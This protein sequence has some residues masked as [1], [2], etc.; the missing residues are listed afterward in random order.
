LPR[1]AQYE[2]RWEAA[3]AAYRTS[4]ESQ[5]ITE[6]TWGTWL[7]QH[8][9]FA[10]QG[11]HGRIN[12]L[13]ERRHGGENGYWY[14]Y[15]RQGKHVIKQYAGRSEQLTLT[16]LEALT[17]LMCADRPIATPAHTAEPTLPSASSLIAPLPLLAAKLQPPRLRTGLVPRER[18]LARLD[19][20]H[21]G[22][23][24]LIAAPAGFGKTTLVNQWVTSR[25]EAGIFS[26]VA[27]LAL[28]AGDADPARFWRYFI[29]TCQRLHPDVGHDAM[30]LLHA[31]TLPPFE[32]PSPETVLTLLLNDLI[33][34]QC[35][36]VLV[37]EDYHFITAPQIH[38]ALVFFIEHLSVGLHLI[39]MTRRDP[40]FPLARW[41]AQGIITEITPA[42]L[43]FTPDETAAFFQA[44]STFT[45]DEKVLAQIESRLEGW[46]AGLRM[47]ALALQGHAQPDQ[48]H[49]WLGEPNGSQWIFGDYF[50]AEV[51]ETQPEEIQQFLLMTSSL[52]RISGELC[53][54]VLERTGSTALLDTMER[55][56]L[57]L[58]PLEQHGNWYRFH[59][60][61]AEA[62]QR[63]AQR[64]LDDARLAGA[65]QRASA[66]Y[67]AHDMLPEAIE[68]ALHIRDFPHAAH[69]I[70]RYVGS[71]L[72]ILGMNNFSSLQEYYTLHRWLETLPETL[73]QRRPALC[74]NFAA[75]KLVSMAMQRS[76]YEAFERIERLLRDAEDGWRRLGDTARLGE[77]FA[78]RALIARERGAI[79]EAITWADQALAWL[80]AEAS[81]WRGVAVSVQGIGAWY[82]ERLEAA[83]SMII[84]AQSLSATLGNRAY[85]RA[86][87]NMLAYITLEMGEL[88]RA[89]QQFRT[90]L[91]EARVD[92]DPDDIGR[93]NGALAQI[94]YEWNDLDAAWAANAETLEMSRLIA[95]EETQSYGVIMRARLWQARGETAPALHELATM[96]E[97][98]MPTLT[99]LRVRL[100]R[101]IRI[102]QA[103]L[104]FAQGNLSAM[105]TWWEE[106]DPQPDDMPRHTVAQEEAL[107]A[108]LL[109]AQGHIAEAQS[110]VTALLDEAQHV[111]RMQFSLQMQILLAQA[112]LGQHDH[113]NARQI[114]RD[115]LSRALPEG[116]IRLFIDNGTIIEHCIRDLI[117][118]LRDPSL[119]RYAAHLLR[120]FA[121]E[122]GEAQPAVEADALSPQELRVLRL[123]VAGH[124]N[125]VIA[126]ELVVSV[127]TVKA[128]VKNLYRKLGVNS[129]V[130]ATHAAR[131][132]HL[133]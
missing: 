2:V 3:E 58:E 76:A 5:P 16:H 97:H 22:A 37:L 132:Q 20:G 15:R 67:A 21:D 120:A 129:R 108:R 43:S 1:H 133:L 80:P 123:L 7:A 18:L 86:N 107:Y 111:G 127:N 71:E 23:L 81:A 110:I 27:W 39:L 10:F 8:R 119:R 44:T 126:Q 24:T 85:V 128:H 82:T 38:A 25:Y 12:L 34:A 106:R 14:A 100:V 130:A 121:Q 19:A 70:E 104:H 60:L 66:W 91:V 33:H 53:D 92:N 54:A 56:G 105:Q 62:M 26:H 79:R 68:T 35:Q 131:Q 88:H 122:R 84:K 96:E 31:A 57:F 42:D 46:A 6:S 112:Y 83:R 109:I 59:A 11:H 4:D 17:R 93:I 9:S 78:F 103:M 74:L 29:A 98:L 51:L 114:M 52:Q 99:P 73:L 63:E 48:M 69:L 30:A 113:M 94:L 49:T 118:D 87:A 75:T 65:V 117:P 32:Q 77:V 115:A 28:D 55:A 72:F 124:S 13:N 50:V 45:P 89:E 90:V 116:Y 125:P 61:F 102:Q 95:D 64:R 101:E 41:R 40:P 36:G 47:L